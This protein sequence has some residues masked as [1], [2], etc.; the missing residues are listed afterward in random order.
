MP[1]FLSIQIFFEDWEIDVQATSEHN[2]ENV[3]K[4]KKTFFKKHG[5]KAIYS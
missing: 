5:Y 3:T 1:F 2:F 4:G